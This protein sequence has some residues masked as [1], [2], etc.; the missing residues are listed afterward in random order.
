MMQ[1]CMQNIF[2]EGGSSLVMLANS[3]EATFLVPG[4]RQDLHLLMPWTSAKDKVN[5]IMCQLV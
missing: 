1:N 4:L 2:P 3:C 5:A